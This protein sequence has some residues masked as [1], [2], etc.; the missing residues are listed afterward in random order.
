MFCAH[1]CL[2]SSRLSFYKEV[3]EQETTNYVHLRAA[4]ER[5]PPLVILRKLADE[6][7]ETTHR[8]DRLVD[9]DVELA[10]L[11]RGYVQV[12]VLPAKS[13]DIT[14]N[15]WMDALGTAL[16]GVFREGPALPTRGARFDGL[17]AGPQVLHRLLA[18]ISH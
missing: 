10:A 4:A 16:P 14:R 8:L 3:K 17:D 6:I 13:A 2:R 11:W 12:S 7:V 18:G 15:S 5:L 1:A 9:D